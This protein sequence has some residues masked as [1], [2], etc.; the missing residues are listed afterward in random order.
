MIRLVDSHTHIFESDFDQDREEVVARALQSGIERML[1]P[2]IEVGTID[3]LYAT[4]SAHSSL[5][6]IALGLHPTSVGANF[7]E[8]LNQIEKAVAQKPHGLVAIGEIG[9]DYY[10]DKSY[11]EEQKES[12]RRQLDIALAHH[13]PVVLHTRD[14]HKEMVDI[15]ETYQ[16]TP[17]KGVFHSFTGSEAELRELLQFRNFCI[18]INGVITFK[19]AT[20]RDFVRLIPLERLLLETDAPY[21][22]PT[23]HRGK[24]NEPSFLRNTLTEVARAYNCSEEEV[25]AVTTDNYYRLFGEKNQT[26]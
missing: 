20:L 8:A 11:Y 21:L 16:E 17:L 2:N 3:A 1:L 5:T 22:A 18:G 6:D 4:H 23:P 12:L 7:R 13:L 14:A 15:I 10:W 9:L 24:R 25:A 19:K 26:D